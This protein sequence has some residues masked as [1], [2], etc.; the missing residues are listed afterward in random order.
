MDF[1]DDDSLDS[2]P[3]AIAHYQWRLQA[4]RRLREAL[5]SVPFYANR[6][7]KA[8]A[9]G[10]EEAELAYWLNLQGSQAA[11]VRPPKKA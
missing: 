3:E 6:A 8:R 4:A 10:G 5:Y 7:D 2:G 1:W 11:L 9:E